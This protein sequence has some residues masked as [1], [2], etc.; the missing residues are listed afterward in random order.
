MA[1]TAAAIFLAALHGF[2]CIL[3]HSLCQLHFW[4]NIVGLELAQVMAMKHFGKLITRFAC[5]Q[6]G[7]PCTGPDERVDTIWL[8]EIKHCQ[9]LGEFLAH[10][11]SCIELLGEAAEELD[12]GEVW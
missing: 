2:P 1:F 12:D 4:K 11:E 3:Q 9:C 5:G 7:C 6:H 8:L 10:E